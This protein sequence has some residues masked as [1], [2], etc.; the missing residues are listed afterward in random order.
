MTRNGPGSG[1]SRI[2]SFRRMPP[3]AIVPP[4]LVGLSRSS[5]STRVAIKHAM[6]YAVFRLASKRLLDAGAAVEHVMAAVFTL[7]ALL[8]VP[9]LV[10][11]DLGWLASGDG[12][13]MALW[14][15]AI[16]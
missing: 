3:T 10:V 2:A 6:L 16:P 8:L 7:G 14:L 12:V 5:A 4:P 1:T 9:V 15:G 13:A 11:G